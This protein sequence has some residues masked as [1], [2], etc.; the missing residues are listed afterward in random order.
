MAHVNHLGPKLIGNA[1]QHT[2][3]EYAK[4]FLHRIGLWAEVE[5]IGGGP[6]TGAGRAVRGIK[7]WHADV[8]LKVKI[9][10]TTE[11]QI[12][13]FYTHQREVVIEKLRAEFESCEIVS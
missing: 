9:C 10:D 1:R 11:S 7:V 6:I 2:T 4:P 5:R 3:I 13:F 12:F 8:G